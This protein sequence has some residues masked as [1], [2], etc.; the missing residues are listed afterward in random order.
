MKDQLIIPAKLYHLF[1]GKVYHPFWDE[2]VIQKC[3]FFQSIFCSWYFSFQS[4]CQILSPAFYPRK[5][6][7]NGRRA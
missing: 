7:E 2:P 6:V 5:A 4:I 1:R 3:F